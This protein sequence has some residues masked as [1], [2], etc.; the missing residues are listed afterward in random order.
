MPSRAMSA[1]AVA[2]PA[3]PVRQDHGPFIRRLKGASI[4]ATALAVTAFGILVANHHAGTTTAATQPAAA[5]GSA[6]GAVPVQAAGPVDPFF[7]PNP[8]STSQQG[9]QPAFGFGG[10]GRSSGPAFQSSGS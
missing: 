2:Q 10:G 7:D 9:V 8:G 6:D 5:K 4:V 3:R 1:A